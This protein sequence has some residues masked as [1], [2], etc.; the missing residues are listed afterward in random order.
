[1]SASDGD[2]GTEMGTVWD[3]NLG[4]MAEDLDTWRVRC[5]WGDVSNEEVGSE[6]GE[7]VVVKVEG[8]TRERKEEVSRL[9]RA[10]VV[11]IFRDVYY[12]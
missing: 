7:D 6:T 5:G 10:R 11:R 9:I 3:I 8:E 12:K 4:K 2:P 1:L